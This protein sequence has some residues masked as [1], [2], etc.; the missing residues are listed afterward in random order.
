MINIQNYI[1]EIIRIFVAL[2]LLM[3]GLSKLFSPLDLVEVIKLFLDIDNS[4]LILVA[5]SIPIVEIF[6]GIMLL[7]RQKPKYTISLTFL[8]MTF[9]FLISVWGNILNIKL[10]CGCFGSL[11]K[12]EFDRIMIIRNF[13]F[14][15]AALSLY[16]NYKKSRAKIN[17]NIGGQGQNSQY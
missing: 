11:I 17:N 16:I 13:V 1:I 6:I 8:I 5:T 4:V 14:F 10:D 12:S 15:L 2:V 7:L 9:F 3:S